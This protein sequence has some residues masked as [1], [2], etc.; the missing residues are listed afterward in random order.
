MHVGVQIKKGPVIYD[1]NWFSNFK[2]NEKYKMGAIGFN[3]N[4]AARM[5]ARNGVS[6]A[7]FGF[8]DVST[9]N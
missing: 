9:I 6:N 1:G 7:Q 4:N 2:N 8:S 5:S 3:R